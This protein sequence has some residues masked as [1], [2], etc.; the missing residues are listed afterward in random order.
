[1]SRPKLQAKT[2]GA[3]KVR[4][5]SRKNSICCEKVVHWAINILGSIIQSRSVAHHL[6]IYK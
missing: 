2:R 5:M 3:T 6:K 1:M 4:T